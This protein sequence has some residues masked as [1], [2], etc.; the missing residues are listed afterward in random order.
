MTNHRAHLLAVAGS[1]CVVAFAIWSLFALN[2]DLGR[3]TLAPLWHSWEI[4]LA[5]TSL[6]LLNYALRAVRWHAYLRQMGYS[7]PRFVS[8]LT[9]IAGFAYTLSPGKLGEIIRARYCAPLGVPLRAVTSAVF[10]ER[11][12]DLLAMAVLA[13]L[14][15]AASPAYRSAI[16]TTAALGAATLVVLLALPWSAIARSLRSFERGGALT[17]V[18]TRAAEIL[19]DVRALLRPQIVLVGFV[20]ALAAWGLEGLGLGLLGRMV[21]TTPL[22]ALPA[23]GIYAVAVLVGA[24]S[25]LPGG[26][27]STEAAMT[28]LLAASGYSVADAL[29][30]TL[31]CR[32]VTLWL[33]VGLG[34]LAILLLRSRPS[35]AEG[36]S[37]LS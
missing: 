8:W 20:I 22:D 11:L 25:F 15:G 30:I 2:A 6:S 34:W 23:I 13:T 37:P 29:L 3:I 7:L 31:T 28:A 26:L 1:A 35:R 16:W 4:V 32:L 19:N 21:G 5:A 10:V 33:A 14:I 27:G 9:Y 36:C 12:M 18:G 17:R 24:L